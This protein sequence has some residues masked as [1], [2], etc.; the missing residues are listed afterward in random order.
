[1]LIK[2]DTFLDKLSMKQC[3]YGLLLIFILVV[4]WGYYTNY[5]KVK[6]LEEEKENAVLNYRAVVGTNRVLNLN[7][8][9]LKNSND[10]KDQLVDSVLKVSKIKPD[11][12]VETVYIK[13][14]V[15]KTD[16][17]KIRDSIIIGELDTIIGNRFLSNRL[18][19]RA[20][21]FI[22][23]NTKVMN[24]KVVSVNQSKEIKGIPS[25]YWIIRLFQRKIKY[26][27]IDIWNSNPYIIE[28]DNKTIRYNID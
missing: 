24:E 13:D 28:L 25:K 2:I 14:T 4:S 18:I 3:L 7:I 20:P 10:K 15:N 16:T 6:A 23:I 8:D 9:D 19:L 22:S 11:K 27:K 5:N 12:V 21:N 26:L 17:I 1:M